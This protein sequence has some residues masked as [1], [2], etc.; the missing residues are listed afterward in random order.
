M[1]YQEIKSVPNVG[2]EFQHL[3]DL[4]FIEGSAG[5]KFA[6]Q[7]LESLAVSTNEVTVKWDGNPT[8]YWGRNTAGEFVLI[9]KNAWGKTECTSPDMLE[10]FILT[11]GKGEP[12]RKTFAESLVKIWPLLEDA[13]PLG[14]CGYVYGDLLFYP[15]KPATL[16]NESLSFTP[17]KVTYS[18]NTNSALGKRISNA[19]VAIAVHSSFK[20]FGSKESTPMRHSEAFESK[21]VAV[22]SQTRVHAAATVDHQQLESVKRTIAQHHDDIDRF[23]A[24]VSGLSDM[25]NIIY[26]YVNQTSKARQLDSLGE[27]FADWLAQ[28]KVSRSKQARILGLAEDTPAALPAIFSLVKQIMSIKNSIIEQLDAGNNEVSAVTLNETG[29]EGYIMLDEKIK[30]V[31]RHRWVPD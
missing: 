27:T 1:K 14:V 4:V 21:A 26:T 10:E 7:V 12:W 16:T 13:T 22:I 5:A 3:E 23:L 19:Q 17:N 8:I 28:S 18:V 29:G 20:E 11:T 24:P 31:P 2:R 6:T 30:L 9:N 15:G 25:R